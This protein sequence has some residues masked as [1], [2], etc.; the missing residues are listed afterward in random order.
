LYYPFL[1]WDGQPGI[2]L[3]SRCCFHARD[4]LM[5]DIIELAAMFEMRRLRGQGDTVFVRTSRRRL[6][7]KAEKERDAVAQAFPDYFN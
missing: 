6:E 7:E 2:F 5:A 1:A 4:G 3:C